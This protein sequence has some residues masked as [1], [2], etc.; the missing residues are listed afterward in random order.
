MNI[1][2]FEIMH[3]CMADTLTFPLDNELVARRL[4]FFS[5][6]LFTQYRVRIARTEE[7]LTPAL[8]YLRIFADPRFVSMG[9]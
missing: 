6:Y 3:A 4:F 5:Q 8:S 1:L 2:T 9:F 7:A